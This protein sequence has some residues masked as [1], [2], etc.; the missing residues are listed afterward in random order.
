MQLR[1]YDAELGDPFPRHCPTAACSP[2][3]IATAILS[4]ALW[5]SPSRG[6]SG[7]VP[8]LKLPA[9]IGALLDQLV[10][11]EGEFCSSSNTYYWGTHAFVLCHSHSGAFF[12]LYRA[13]PAPAQRSAKVLLLK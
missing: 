3:T 9:V 5:P 10:M 4:R 8:Q 6:T 12:L 7:T 11:R 1:G 13:V 2:L